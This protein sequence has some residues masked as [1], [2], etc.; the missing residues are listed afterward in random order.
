MKDGEIMVYKITF[1]ADVQGVASV[2]RINGEFYTYGK[3]SA[4][5]KHFA[6][7]FI[8]GCYGSDY[9]ITE[10]LPVYVWNME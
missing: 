9:A 3:D 4:T 10:V 6:E 2:K 8:E 5:A 1:E 7:G